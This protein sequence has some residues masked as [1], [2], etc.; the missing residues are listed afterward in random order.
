MK[1]AIE[2]TTQKKNKTGQGKNCFDERAVGRDVMQLGSHQSAVR[3]RQSAVGSL[4]SAFAEAIGQY[5]FFLE[6]SQIRK[7]NRSSPVDPYMR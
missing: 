7:T 4:K 3:S 1:Y 6:K 5:F 2:L